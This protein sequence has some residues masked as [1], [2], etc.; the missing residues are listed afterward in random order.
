MVKREKKVVK[1]E[2]NWLLER[3]L[4]SFD[5][6]KKSGIYI[7]VI[8][9]LLFFTS[10]VG[11]FLPGLF[12]DQA[13]KIIEEMIRSL[14]GKSTNEL[15]VHIFLNNMR[16]G[17]FAMVFGVLFGL[18]PILTSIINGYLIG[19][20]S[21]M[22]VSH[23]GIT[24]LWRLVPHGIFEIPA[25]LLSMGIGLYLGSRF[26]Q[27]K[28]YPLIISLL[29]GKVSK[30]DK[31]SK[32]TI[33]GVFCFIC[34]LLIPAIIFYYLFT[35]FVVSSGNVLLTALL[36]LFNL[37]FL[38]LLI[39]SFYLFLKDKDLRSDLVDSLWFFILIVFPLLFLAGIIEGL[40]MGL[41]R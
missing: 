33:L 2:T 24:I 26:F 34:V 4:R 7:F 11:F 9:L 18:F 23:G 17:F 1:K 8:T 36:A 25:I 38:G 29:G 6:V 13:M 5:L 32:I 37:G 20:A 16:A 30:D 19:F 10:I 35:L 12:E 3:Y 31:N 27:A 22:A 40:L 21:N 28:G 39:F 15:I 41:M 14:D